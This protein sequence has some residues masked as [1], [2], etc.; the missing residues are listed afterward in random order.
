MSGK[1]DYEIETSI[2]IPQIMASFDNP[3]F[4]K[5]AA[6]TW[7]KLYEDFVPCNTGDLYDI[8]RIK[9]WKIEHYVPYAV[10]V[11]THNRHYRKDRHPKATAHWSEAAEPTEEKKLI[12]SM[13]KYIN[14]GRLPIN[15]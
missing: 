6:D 2:N 12:N 3:S 8:V 13:Q 4:G 14:E 1:I 11:Y 7:Y 5:F 10:E 15:D 9:A